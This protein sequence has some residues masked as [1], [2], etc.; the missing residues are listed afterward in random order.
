MKQLSN[1]V[2]NEGMH[3]AQHHFQAQSRFFEDTIQFALSS[4]FFKPYGVA[5]CELNNEALQNDTVALVH[6]RGVMPDGLPF[7]IPAS[8]APVA[9][10][11]I[12][13]RFSPTSDSHLVLLAI[14]A[15]RPDQSNFATNGAVARVEV[16]TSPLRYTA[17]AI[18]VRDAITGRDERSLSVGR[19]NFRLML[20][21]ASVG[22]ELEGLVSLPIARV[23][24]DGAGH[25][26]YD[27]DYIAPSLHIGASQRLVSLV[28]RIN[29][30]LDAKADTI[31]RGR[32]GSADEFAQ[33]EVASFWLLH[34]INASTP[35]LRHY[36]QS[37][38]VHPERLYVEL[39]RLAGALCTF[40]LDAHPRALPPYDHDQP[41]HCFDALDRHIRAHLELVSPSRRS[42]ISFAPSGPSLYTA[43]VKDARAFG[44]ARW[45]LGARS[46]MPPTEL[47][48]QLPILAKLCSAKF[49]LELVKRAY[50]GMTLTHLPYP[51]ATIGPRGDMQ[52]FDV[53]RAG[54]CWDTIVSTQQVGIYVPDGIPN[55]ELELSIIPDGEG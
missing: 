46:T 50:P 36:A 31:A 1:I 6:A 18:T 30:I 25:F 55:V 9:P 34:A 35:T 42:A 13:D 17:E 51:P 10:L 33:R 29:D 14:P 40:A 44:P 20:D 41:E 19:K 8:D 49:V 54:P 48:A 37:K 12:A 53:T 39:A 7:D 24:R 15:Y 2:W 38:H 3:L 32:R 21:T 5:A 11:A 16:S 45:I 26:M 43:P 28:Q 27:A 4:L 23:R 52:Y 47:A 22:S